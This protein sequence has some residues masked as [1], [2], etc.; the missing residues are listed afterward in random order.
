M[1]EGERQLK[2]Q[3][4]GGAIP[5]LLEDSKKGG[6]K[7]GELHSPSFYSKSGEKGEE[8]YP[9]WRRKEGGKEGG[10]GKTFYLFLYNQSMEREGAGFLPVRGR[11]GRGGAYHESPGRGDP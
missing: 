10:R 2:P 9:F 8:N 3:Q 4:R 5:F 11:K 1:K 6:G 7:E